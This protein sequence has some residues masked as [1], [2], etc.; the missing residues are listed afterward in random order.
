MLPCSVTTKVVY[1]QLQVKITMVENVKKY[2][3]FDIFD[4][5]VF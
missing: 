5:L 1:L 3:T 2:Y 4:W